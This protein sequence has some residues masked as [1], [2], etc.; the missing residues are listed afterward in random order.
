MNMKK[1][2]YF[3]YNENSGFSLF[4]NFHTEHTAV[5]IILI[6]LSFHP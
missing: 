3:P 1:Y 5:S 6:M 2:Y 4:H